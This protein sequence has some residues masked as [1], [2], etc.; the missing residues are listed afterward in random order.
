MPT[1]PIDPRVLPL[2][3]VGTRLDLA[4]TAG[5]PIQVVKRHD[6]RVEIHAAGGRTAEL[7]AA[8]AHALGAFVTGHYAIDPALTERL[9]DVLGGL[10]FDWVHVPRGAHA[11]GRSIEDLAVRR[12]TGVTIVAILRGSIPIVAPE[13]SV[14]LAAGDD[15]VIA[16]RE[17]D[18]ERFERYITAGP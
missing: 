4:D 2:P 6:G 3:G 14:R 1:S 5:S 12:R 7:D 10:L 17:Q 8:N 13:P 11:V 16:C 9:G 18:R 15:L